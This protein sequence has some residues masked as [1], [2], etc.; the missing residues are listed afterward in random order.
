MHKIEFKRL[1][2]IIQLLFRLLKE[3]KNDS[4]FFSRPRS[5]FGLADHWQSSHPFKIYEELRI[6]TGTFL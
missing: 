3:V 4:R 5:Y 6:N 1:H 2:I